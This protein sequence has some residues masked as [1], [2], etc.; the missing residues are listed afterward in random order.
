MQMAQR[1]GESLNSSECGDV[2]P[3]NVCCDF[4]C[5]TKGA[6]QANIVEELIKERENMSQELS[7]LRGDVTGEV[8][9]LFR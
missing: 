8:T 4:G 3:A 5:K 2:V 1:R 7:K 9:S 6:L